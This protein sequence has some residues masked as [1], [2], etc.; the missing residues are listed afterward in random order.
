MMIS[1]EKYPVLSTNPAG[2]YAWAMDQLEG[3]REVRRKGWPIEVDDVA[4][5]LKHVRI[6]RI[7]RTGAAI[8]KGFNVLTTDPSANDAWGTLGTDG[9]IYTPNLMDIGS[10]DWQTVEQV[11]DCQIDHLNRHRYLRIPNTY[12]A[13]CAAQQKRREDKKFWWT[14]FWFAFFIAF[15]LSVLRRH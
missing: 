12:K 15:C 4:D 13:E 8:F 7:Y 14:V 3:G 2:S 10:H 1:F 5:G 6:W 11:T 9:D